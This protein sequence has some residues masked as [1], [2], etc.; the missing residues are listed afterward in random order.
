MNVAFYGRVGSQAV[1]DA[2]SSIKQQEMQVRA[3]C[4]EQGYSVT[5]SFVDVG[6]SGAN[7]NRPEFQQML[8]AAMSSPPPFQAIVVESLTKF[9]RNILEL[10]LHIKQ[11]KNNGVALLSAT[12]AANDNCTDE[13]I[14]QMLNTFRECT[15]RQNTTTNK[16]RTSNANCRL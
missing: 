9:H 16:R 6:Q 5:A 2:T 12:Q 3:W 15:C 14:M 8:N 13:L 10:M 11:L 4:E 7:D 1:A